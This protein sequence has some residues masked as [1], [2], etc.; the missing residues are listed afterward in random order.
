MLLVSDNAVVAYVLLVA[1]SIVASMGVDWV[2]SQ[3]HKIESCVNT[4]L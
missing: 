1:V 2:W 4:S 3:M